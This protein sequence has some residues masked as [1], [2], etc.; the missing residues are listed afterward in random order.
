MKSM[1]CKRRCF[2]KI[3][4]IFIILKSESCKT[5]SELERVLL[6]NSELDNETL[7]ALLVSIIQQ[8]NYA[9][10]LL[11]TTSSVDCPLKDV[12]PALQ[13]PVLRL[14]LPLPD[15]TVEYHERFSTNV[16]ILS[17]VADLG[18]WLAAQASK[19]LR[20]LNNV[21]QVWYLAQYNA[22]KLQQLCREA[23]RFDVYN[24]IVVVQQ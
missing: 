13:L 18:G 15:T 14:E 8:R 20:T 10:I 2:I 24:L 3:W 22:T 1:Q 9:N 16:L 7:N 6:K 4:F 5:A 21:H 11:L 23:L 12:L 19:T 17:C